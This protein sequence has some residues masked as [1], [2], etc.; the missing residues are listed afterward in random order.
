M[1]AYDDLDDPSIPDG[2]LDQIHDPLIDLKMLTDEQSMRLDDDRRIQS[3]EGSQRLIHYGI[4][5]R[6]PQT[7]IAALM[8]TTRQTLLLLIRLDAFMTMVIGHKE[9]LD[10]LS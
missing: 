2:G 3:L 1:S 7:W 6:Q 5:A 8:V 10:E 4:L 9:I